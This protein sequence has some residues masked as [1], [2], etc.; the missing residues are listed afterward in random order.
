M[1]KLAVWLLVLGSWFLVVGSVAGEQWTMTITNSTRCIPSRDVAAT[2][3]VAWTNRIAVTA[4]SYYANTNSK[5]FM[6][7]TPGTSTN[8]PAS[9]FVFTGSD[10]ITWL[11][12]GTFRYPNGITV[13]VNSGAEVHYNRNAAATTNCPWTVK[14]TFSVEKTSA[15]YF[16]APASGTSTISFI[17]E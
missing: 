7:V 17:T 6:A 4:G 15:D 12:C 9:A 14:R 16:F 13:C 11:N 2:N 5:V 8:M 1:K 3:A 10:G